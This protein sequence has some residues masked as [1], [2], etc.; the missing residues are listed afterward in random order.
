MRFGVLIGLSATTFGAALAVF[1]CTT[2]YQKGLDDP[3]IGDP[4]TLENSQQPGPTNEATSTAKGG[5]GGGPVC[6][7]NGGTVVTDGGPCTVSFKTDVLGAFN[8]ACTAPTCHGGANPAVPPKINPDDP[9]G[10]YATFVG[11]TMR[12][13]KFYVNSCSQDDKQ[14]GMACNLAATGACGTKMP[15]GGQIPQETI[16]KIE[17]WLKCGAPNN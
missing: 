13:G 3:R 2:D 8:G 7:Q 15:I 5:D 17:T 16:T 9:S 6:K 12:G 1:A 11:F 14:S 4:N 10:T